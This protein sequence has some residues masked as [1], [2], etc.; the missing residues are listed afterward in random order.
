M[1]TPRPQPEILLP[2]PGG[3][4]RLFDD[5]NLDLLSHV[6]E[7]CF[8]IPGTSIRFGIDG[9]I[10]LIPGLGDIITGL[11]ACII[12]VAAW[13]RGV[14][15]I[16][17]VRMLVNVAIDIVIGAIPFI[18]DVFDIAWKANRRNYKLLTRHLA[19]PHHHTWRDW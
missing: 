6:L 10:G 8:R 9:I 18:G 15:Y 2:R 17:L 5:E 11:A 16:T 14:P 1:Q 3:G 7:D 4:R 13:F 19:E 12:V